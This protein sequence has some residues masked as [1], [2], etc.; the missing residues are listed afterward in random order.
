MNKKNL[1]IGVA[2]AI[3][4]V[5]LVASYSRAED[6]S[7]IPA[8]PKDAAEVFERY[9]KAAGGK[10]AINAI[11]S[12]VTRGQVEISQFNISGKT[13]TFQKAPNLFAASTAL[14][15]GSFDRVFNGTSAWSKNPM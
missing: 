8:E 13:E 5:G 7:T 6:G 15:M 12:R 4:I 2:T 9:A 11:K 1:A 3:G 14:D 10:A